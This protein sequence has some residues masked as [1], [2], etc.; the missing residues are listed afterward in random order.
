MPEV[1]LCQCS[2]ASVQHF[3]R[4]D[5]RQIGH[6]LHRLEGTFVQ[7]LYEWQVVGAIC[8]APLGFIKVSFISF[9]SIQ[10]RVLRRE[11]CPANISVA[12]PLEPR[13][14]FELCEKVVQH[15]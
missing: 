7:R 14:R 2:I 6:R 1:T 4:T 12:F 15:A 13:T 9:F 5:P 3:L 11:R 10:A 8:V